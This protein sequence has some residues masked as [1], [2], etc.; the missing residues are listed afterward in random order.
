[1]GLFDKIMG[2]R[3]A[4]DGVSLEPCDGGYRLTGGHTGSPKF[5]KVGVFFSSD[6]PLKD[7][8]ELL[9]GI[10]LEQDVASGL[11][12]GSVIMVVYG[13]IPDIDGFAATMEMS[14]GL[15]AFLMARA[16]LSG[17][18]RGPAEMAML[19]VSPFNYKGVNGVIIKKET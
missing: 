17:L 4:E 15:N 1:M 5:G 10:L 3:Q 13:P 19:A 16:M 18:A 11:A 2:K 6:A 8:A 14:E 7:E 12:S 9:K